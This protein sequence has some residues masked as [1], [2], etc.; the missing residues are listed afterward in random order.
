[1]IDSTG[2]QIEGADNPIVKALIKK[3]V[4]KKVALT[5]TPNQRLNLFSDLE[6]EVMHPHIREKYQKMKLGDPYLKANPGLTRAKAFARSG[7]VLLLDSDA[8]GNGR[9]AG[10]T[11]IRGIKLMTTGGFTLE[12]TIKIASLNGATFLKIQDRT[13]SIAVGKEADL[14]IV[15]CDPSKKIED[16]E[17]VE[18]V[19]SN[20]ILYDPKA[21]ISAAKGLVGWQ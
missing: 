11:N 5:L 12:E 20:G 13:G 17:K 14:F 10:F 6:L 2:K 1:M 4:N 21:L 9:I 3:L 16:I 19:F 18:M 8:A 7:G 15:K